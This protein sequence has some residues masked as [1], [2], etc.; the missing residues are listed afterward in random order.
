LACAQVAIGLSAGLANKSAERIAVD[1]M[2]VL[3]RAG[4]SNGRWR[5]PDRWRGLGPTV[6]LEVLPGS[7]GGL[8]KI[9]L[10]GVP[11]FKSMLNDGRSVVVFCK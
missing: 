9:S 11:L 4:M 3:L 1:A 7:I 10:S 2:V 6:T 5:R 8:R